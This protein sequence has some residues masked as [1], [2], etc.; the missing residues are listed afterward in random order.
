MATREELEAENEK[1]KKQLALALDESSGRNID[2]LEAEN[3]QLEKIIEQTKDR[4]VKEEALEM[5]AQNRKELLKQEQA[6]LRQMIRD[7]E[8]DL[9]DQQKKVRLLREQ[10]DASQQLAQYQK[11]GAQHAEEMGQALGD[12]M[13]VTKGGVVDVKKFAGSI[14]GATK[15]IGKGLKGAKDWKEGLAT[16]G[17]GL[18]KFATAGLFSIIQIWIDMATVVFEVNM[19][20][21]NNTRAIQKNNG[22]SR[23]MAEEIAGATDKVRDFTHEFENLAKASDSLYDNFTDFTMVSAATRE[24][25]AL[26]A[27]MLERLGVSYDSF[28]NSAQ[29]AT[30]GLGVASKDTSAMMRNL[31]AYAMDI[32]T[33]VN[34]LT[35]AFAESGGTLTKFGDS[36][37][38]AFKDLARTAKITGIDIQRL[39]AITEKFDTFEGAAEQAGML[40]AALGGNMVN[41]MDLMMETDPAA[42]FDMIRSSIMGAAGS[43]DDLGY[44]QKIYLAKAAGLQDVGELAL[45]MSGNYDLLDNSMNKN[46]DDYVSMAQKAKEW[47]SV[48]EQLKTMLMKL[49][50]TME[51][52]MP[53]V[54]ELFDFLATDEAQEK[55]KRFFSTIEKGI[56]WLAEEGN[57]ESLAETL[58]TVGEN[59]DVI[60]MALAAIATAGTGLSIAA[61]VK[62]MR[63]PK[64]PPGGGGG[65]GGPKLPSGTKPSDVMPKGSQPPVRGAANVADKTASASA[66]ATQKA[67]AATAHSADDAAAAA[68]AAAA[69]ADEVAVATGKYATYFGQGSKFATATQAL[70][71]VAVPLQLALGAYFGGKEMA[72]QRG[73]DREEITWEEERHAMEMSIVKSAGEFASLLDLPSYIKNTDFAKERG[74][75]AT[76]V[77]DGIAMLSTWGG[78]SWESSMDYMRTDGMNEA[79]QTM[80]IPFFD[81]DKKDASQN[82]FID[83]VENYK[84]SGMNQKDY[85]KSLMK[86][87][88]GWEGELSD[89]VAEG[90]APIETQFADVGT[91][92]GQ[93]LADKTEEGANA[94]MPGSLSPFAQK[95]LDGILGLDEPVYEAM[96]KPFV[97]AEELITKIQENIVQ[98]A[99][100]I[101]QVGNDTAAAAST[102]AGGAPDDKKP[103]VVQ[104]YMDGI[105][106]QEQVIGTIGTAAGF[107]G[108]TG[109]NL[110]PLK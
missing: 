46:A 65:T 19:A 29:W 41:A 49:V 82:P 54:Q 21:E 53:A 75:E 7:G 86:P 20:V 70:G 61:W 73:V 44:Y 59:L 24:E 83:V 15:K 97:R 87:P 25:M 3:E 84:G 30:K 107:S 55:A 18:T 26:N 27:T 50:P 48:Q 2:A 6:T 94:L 110:T 10:R 106:K 62:K 95:I 102:T 68:Q 22:M 108:I 109:Y 56:N 80:N 100:M 85:L 69:S 98:Q 5:R 11:E 92:A 28:S 93:A 77:M 63:G 23:Q 45:M 14:A 71:K 74:W 31:T 8:T 96:V 47:Q 36:G 60:A 81:E 42:R 13:R 89:A 58:A 9:A 91:K 32:G 51:K 76:G 101:T 17:K 105:L 90:I 52:I 57:V 79:S 40:N 99:Q 72:A 34:Q 38:E 37:V 67:A 4:V 88:P 43:F 64:T 39:L 78:Q 103:V 33:D 12:A 66:S 1:L 104:I 35:S 16:L